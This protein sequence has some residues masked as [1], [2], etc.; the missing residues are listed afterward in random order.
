MKGSSG[1]SNL[2]HVLAV[3]LVLSLVGIAFL[4]FVHSLRLEE[5]IRTETPYV[6]E[7]Q[8]DYPSDSLTSLQ[9]DLKKLRGVLPSSVLFIPKED[10]IRTMSEEQALDIEQGENPFFDILVLSLDPRQDQSHTIDQIQQMAKA[11]NLTV[12]AHPPGQAAGGMAQALSKIKSVM[13]F[14]TLLLTLLAFLIIGYLVRI[15]FLSKAPVI[16][17]MSLLGAE[18]H[19][20]FAPYTRLAI[21]HGLA[22]ALMAV[23]LMGLALLALYYLA[24]WIYQLLDLKN[25]ILTLLVLLMA[26][27]A[28]HYL[29]IRQSI[30]LFQK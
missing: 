2:L 19:K 12:S 25:F 9:L 26:S 16:R 30:K 22:S 8:P 15:F 3:A 5:R 14:S 23:S 10:A 28:M 18:D 20:I 21:I 17:L 29:S 1:S 6:L 4:T 24:P 11:K 27:P 13:I 7:L